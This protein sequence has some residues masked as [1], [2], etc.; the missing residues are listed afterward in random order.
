MHTI[1]DAIGNTPILSVKG[2]NVKLEY[3]NPSGSI[4][5]RIAKH[6]IDM[7]EKRK[8]LKRGYIDGR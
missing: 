2:I 4:K 7:A 1:L 8:L 3:M 5:D 6:I